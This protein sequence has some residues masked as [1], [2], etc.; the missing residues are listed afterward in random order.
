MKNLPPTLKEFCEK[1]EM[2]RLAYVDQDGQPRVVPLWFVTIGREYYIGTG[3]KSP[4]WKAIQ[5]EPRVG[6]AIDGKKG[7]YKGVSMYGHAEEV[8]E[9]QLRGRIYRALGKKY[10][11]SPDNPKHIELWGQVDDS[12]STFIRLV[13]QDG[14]WW[15]Y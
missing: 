14:F 9:L 2:L 4:K 12:A 1:Q 15:E 10:Y 5:K 6:W 11:G 7:K 3:S 13:T 8:T